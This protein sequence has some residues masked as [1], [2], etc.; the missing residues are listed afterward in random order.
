MGRSFVS[1][2][3]PFTKRPSLFFAH[4]A[5]YSRHQQLSNCYFTLYYTEI[6]TVNACALDGEYFDQCILINGALIYT[7]YISNSQNKQ[8]IALDLKTN[9]RHVLTEGVLIGASPEQNKLY[10]VN[11]Y[12]YFAYIP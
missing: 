9:E 12:K 10:Y 1:A 8:V 7:P 6:E 11:R 5:S 4:I 2:R 3:K